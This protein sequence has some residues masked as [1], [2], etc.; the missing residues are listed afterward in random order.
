MELG[1]LIPPWEGVD[2]VFLDLPSALAGLLFWIALITLI[3]LRT[4]RDE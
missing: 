4:A 2:N 3:L 1:S